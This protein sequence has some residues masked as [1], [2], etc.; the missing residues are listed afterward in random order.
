[1]QLGA[2]VLTEDGYYGIVVGHREIFLGNGLQEVL[3]DQAWNALRPLPINVNH[4]GGFS[5][6]LELLERSAR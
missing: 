1:M 5:N 3:N 6:F 2:L 4:E